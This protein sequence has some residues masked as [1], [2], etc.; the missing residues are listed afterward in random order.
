MIYCRYDSPTFSCKPEREYYDTALRTAHVSDPSQTYFIDDSRTNVKA[1]QALGWGHV[2]HF[3]EKGIEAVEGGKRK[4]IGSDE[5]GG[6]ITAVSDLQ[7]LREVWKEIFK[8]D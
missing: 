3:L 7:Q 6:D 4:V 2:V 8:T 1:A 5:A